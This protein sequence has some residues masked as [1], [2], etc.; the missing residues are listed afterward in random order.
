MVLSYKEKGQPNESQPYLEK[1]VKFE[2]LRRKFLN[3]VTLVSGL[4]IR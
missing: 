4:I 3:R 1:S 2:Y